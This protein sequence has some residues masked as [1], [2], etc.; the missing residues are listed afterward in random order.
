MSEE[1]EN[2]NK[3]DRKGPSFTFLSDYSHIRKDG[4]DQSPTGKWVM[5]FD[6]VDRQEGNDDDTDAYISSTTG[7]QLTDMR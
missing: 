6:K 4:I 5:I 1:N 7:F 3:Y 2:P